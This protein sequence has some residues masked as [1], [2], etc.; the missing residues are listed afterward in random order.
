MDK[1]RYETVIGVLKM[2][3]SHG[4]ID[5]LSSFGISDS[6]W[7]LTTRRAPWIATD[8]GRVSRTLDSLI[9]GTIDLVG[10]PRFLVPAEYIAAVL[11]C[12]VSPGNLMLAAAWRDGA[13]TAER[14]A[15]EENTFGAEPVRAARLFSLCCE[16]FSSDNGQISAS[17][18]SFEKRVGLAIVKATSTA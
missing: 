13:P 12:F 15:G 2:I 14:L 16:L 8:R 10:L 9:H 6:D 5:S 7:K 18:A 1:V 4:L 3:E 17:R 11:V